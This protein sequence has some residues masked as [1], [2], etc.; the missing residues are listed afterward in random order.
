MENGQAGKAGRRRGWLPPFLLGFAT[1]IASVV[2]LGIAWIAMTNV[3]ARLKCVELPGGATIEYASFWPTE[4][5]MFWPAWLAT[6]WPPQMILRDAAGRVLIKSDNSVRFVRV[7]PDPGKVIL[8]YGRHEDET[9]T[10]DGRDFMPLIYEPGLFGRNWNDPRKIDPNNLSVMWTDLLSIHH[11][12]RDHSE[13]G[14]SWCR[15]IWVSD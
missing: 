1:S 6:E 2:V 4:Y 5:K 9:L 12:L 14:R 15:S 7:P 10:L 11:A 3:A 13:Y 8:T